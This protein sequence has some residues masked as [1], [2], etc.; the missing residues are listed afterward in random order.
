MYYPIN[1][2]YLPNSN[3]QHKT[4]D[5]RSRR[6]VIIWFLGL[7]MDTPKL[8][9]SNFYPSSWYKGNVQDRVFSKNFIPYWPLL[10][11]LAGAVG[12][13]A[14][15]LHLQIGKPLLRARF[16][17]IISPAEQACE[18]NAIAKFYKILRMDQSRSWQTLLLSKVCC[19]QRFA[20]IVA[21]RTMK[22]PQIGMSSNI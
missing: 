9:P 20:A 4:H 6:D 7:P 15:G 13:R 10:S 1:A 12:D 16:E 8:P 14:R 2:V 17:Y 21:F 5:T 19:F 22:Q 18:I 3:C 11:M